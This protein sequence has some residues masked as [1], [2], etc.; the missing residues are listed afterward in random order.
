LEVIFTGDLPVQCFYFRH[1]TL[2]GQEQSGAL[3]GFS[4]PE[5][6][7][8][9]EKLPLQCFKQKLGFSPGTGKFAQG[10]KLDLHRRFVQVKSQSL[11]ALLCP[12]HSPDWHQLRPSTKLGSD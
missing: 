9:P 5:Q 10:R 7:S 6:D 11:G 4:H 2:K 1:A 12:Q 3:P 8:S